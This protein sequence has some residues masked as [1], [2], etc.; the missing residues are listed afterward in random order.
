MSFSRR[1]FL[2]FTAAAAV[3]AWAAEIPRPSPDFSINL[4]DGTKLP[5]NKFR[6]K[7]V[8]MTFISTT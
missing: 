7:V 4:A 5:L 3:P 6:G 2:A 1:Y 8:V